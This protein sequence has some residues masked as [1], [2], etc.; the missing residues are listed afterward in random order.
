MNPCWILLL[1][2][3]PCLGLGE[4]DDGIG[5]PDNK[6]KCVFSKF[7]ALIVR[8][9]E[10]IVPSEHKQRSTI[11]CGG[12]HLKSSPPKVVDVDDVILLR[13][14]EPGMPDRVNGYAHLLETVEQYGF[15]GYY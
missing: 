8:D 12:C 14:L 4:R 6:L 10:P 5:I 3:V 9:N 1:G 7:G 2:K 11:T 13:G 15:R